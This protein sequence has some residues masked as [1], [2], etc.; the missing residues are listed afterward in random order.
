MRRIFI[1]VAAA[2]LL[3]VTL[4]G[5]GS[6]DSSGDSKESVVIGMLVP[7]T[8]PVAQTAETMRNVVEMR[9][10][11]INADGGVDGKDIELKVYDT[12][13]D[14]A[15]AAKQAQRAITQDKVAALLGPFTTSEALAVADVTERSEMVNMNVSAATEAITA[16]K[17][18]V[19]RT[20]PL[21]GDLA[22]GMMQVAK[23]LGNTNGVLLYDGGGFGLGAKDPIEAA[24]K[25]ESVT[26]TGSVKYPLDA[27]DVSAQV[28]AAA[29]GDPGAVFIAGSA[30]ADHGVVA[31]AMIEQGLKVPLIGFSPIGNPD[32]IKI[33]DKAYEELPGVYTLQCVDQTNPLYKKLLEDYNAKFTPVKQLGEQAVQSA[34]GLD[35]IVMGLEKSGG[36]GGKDL[37]TALQNLP[38][39]ETAAG[40]TGSM[41]Q[42]AEGDHDAYG[43]DYLVA[44]RVEGGALVQADI[45]LGGN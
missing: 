13:T 31:K 22:V 24:A 8:G 44:Y 35:W 25:A 4:A 5:C 27:S 45:V 36:K 26:L 9:V 21:T 20:S 23:A 33:A 14:P 29:K 42:F 40:R 38:A 11:Q 2:A 7:L 1:P 10:D 17:S 12:K 41:Q 30:G 6:G 43:K 15:E 34:V 37:V 28:T 19:F 3:S 18:F 16:G 39:R 32:A